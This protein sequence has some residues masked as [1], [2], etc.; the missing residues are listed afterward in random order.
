[1]FTWGIYKYLVQIKH[2][3]YSLQTTPTFWAL[4]QPQPK[5]SSGYTFNQHVCWLQILFRVESDLVE[6]FLLNSAM[7]TLQLLSVILPIVMN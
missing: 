5:K 7:L 4:D 3:V 2:T 6:S 1:M